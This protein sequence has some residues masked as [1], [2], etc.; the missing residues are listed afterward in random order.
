LT[1]KGRFYTFTKELVEKIENNFWIDKTQN[2]SI[3][4]CEAILQSASNLIETDNY[5]ISTE[6]LPF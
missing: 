5:I 3:T 4:S 1:D 6:A 2:Q